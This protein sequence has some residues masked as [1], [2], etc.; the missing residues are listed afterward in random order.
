[1][2]EF[3][4]FLLRKYNGGE[5]NAKEYSQINILLGEFE[6]EEQEK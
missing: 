4:L 3:E 6:K 5:M 1:M 2:K